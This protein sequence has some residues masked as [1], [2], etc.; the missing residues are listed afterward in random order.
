MI[1][2]EQK[3]RI[4]STKN[5]IDITDS[6][7]AIFAIIFIMWPWGILFIEFIH[8]VF[9]NGFLIQWSPPKMLACFSYPIVMTLLIGPLFSN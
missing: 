2:D 5:K 4:S 1:L 7:I 3:T 8:W 6:V 9:M